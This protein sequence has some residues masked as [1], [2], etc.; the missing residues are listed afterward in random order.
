M[1][2]ALTVVFMLGC[3][4]A[5]VA[6]GS[7]APQAPKKQDPEALKLIERY[8][9]LLYIPRAA[10]LKDLEFTTKLP[11][12][13]NLVLRWK[14][15]DKKKADLVVPADAPADRARQLAFVIPKFQDDARKHGPSFI[16]PLQTGEILHEKHKDD[17]ITLVAPN[18]IR[19]VAR[20]EGS[21]RMF[22]EETLTF[23]D[24]GLVKQA[25][26]VSPA[27]LESV[28]EPTFT[29]WN[30]KH[31]YQVLKTKIGQE[32]QVVTF[33]YG[34]FDNVML[35][36][37][38]VTSAKVDGKTREQVLEFFDF[39]VN[40]GLDDKLFEEKPAEPKPQ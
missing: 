40:T 38:V 26:V 23:D 30:G 9:S 12:G 18:Q 29:P 1:K 14:E 13:H 16:D 33:D 20:S 17:D 32:E 7:E 19:I 10:G 36:K 2:C 34:I 39:K 21:K 4:A 35:V 15:P 27:G 6:Q 3:V 28:L 11:S 25:R 5:I 24:Q 31:V 8:D 22:K 37:K